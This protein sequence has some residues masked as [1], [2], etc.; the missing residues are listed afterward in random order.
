MSTFP[1]GI[2]NASAGPSGGAQPVAA[3]LFDAA[4]TAASAAAAVMGATGVNGV[5]ADEPIGPVNGKPASNGMLFGF[6]RTGLAYTSKMKQHWRPD[7][8]NDDSDE[9]DDEDDFEPERPAR[10]SR[11]WK[12]LG[13]ESDTHAARFAQSC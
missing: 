4:A 9:D 6:R 13:G 12:K 5:V 2:S 3:V 10:I 8:A 11:V 7:R 1:N